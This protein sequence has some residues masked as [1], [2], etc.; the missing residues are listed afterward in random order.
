[1]ENPLE[2]TILLVESDAKLRR[3]EAALLSEM[4]YKEIL[5]AGNGTEAWSVIK[6][7]DV[8]FIVCAWEL[9]EMNGLVLLKVVRADIAHS[10][11]PFL[12]VVEEVTKAQVVE[13]GQAGV[14][15]IILRPFTK[16][17][18]LKKVNQ[19][20]SIE[21]DPQT[22]EANRL[23]DNG[24][25]LMKQGDYEEALK[26]FKRILNVYETAEVYYNMGYIKTAQGRYEEAI[27]AFRRATQINNAFAQ[28]FQKMGEAYSKIGHSKEAQKCYEQAA[29]IFMDKN[30]DDNA[31]AVYMQA[32]KVNPGT[33]NVYNSLGILYRRQGKLGESIKM[34]RKA[35]KV[36]P[37]DENIHYNL[38]RVYMADKKLDN[39]AETLRA[40]INLNP[41]FKEAENLL[42]SIEMG[43]GLK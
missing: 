27:V 4:G 36:S 12:L 43:N 21:E 13:A 3:S 33:I 26:S 1:M 31:E 41:D 14:T 11:I 34:Y 20:I 40:A 22:V 16:E 18:F 32:L 42:K 25:E 17:L 2:T 28:A 30:M 6:N 10:M 37:F 29:E 39:A 9:R 38:A 8:G 35:L 24:L 5:Q 7:S 19:T 23:Y 15:D